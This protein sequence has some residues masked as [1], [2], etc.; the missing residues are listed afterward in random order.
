VE[1]GDSLVPIYEYQCQSCDLELEKL[2][3]MSDDTLVDCP[4]CEQPELKRLISAAAFRLK[5]SGWYE[6]D[7]K[8]DNKRN[9]ADTSGADASNKKSSGSEG[10]MNGKSATETSSKKPDSST[11]EKPAAKPVT[12]ESKNA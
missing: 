1:T 11:A 5:G 9:L 2:Q 12:K 8:K 6:T 10:K 3:K 4:E 7:F